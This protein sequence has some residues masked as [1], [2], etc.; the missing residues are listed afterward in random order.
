[1][2]NAPSLPRSVDLSRSRGTW[3][4]FL[5]SWLLTSAILFCTGT[6][7]LAL[8]GRFYLWSWAAYDPLPLK[9]FGPD[10]LAPDFTLRDLRG[11]PFHLAEELQKSPVVLEIG[12][13]T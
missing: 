9:E 3:K 10:D 5:A 2:Q 7:I 4:H 1:M 13:F 11:R 8:N 6:L 12:S